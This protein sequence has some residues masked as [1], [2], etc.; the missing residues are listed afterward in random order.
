MAIKLSSGEH[1]SLTQLGGS[2][3]NRIA[4]GLGW[5]HRKGFLGMAQDV[6]L[7]ASAILFDADKN[8]V[9]DVWFG[10]LSSKKGSVQHLGDDRAGGRDEGDPNEVIIVD[11]KSIPA[12]I[13]SVVFVVSSFSGE[14][15]NGVPFAFCNVVDAASRKEIARYDLQSAEGEHTGY[16][17]AKVVKIEG[18]WKFHAVGAHCAG[19]QRTI[20]DIQAIARQHA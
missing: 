10:H 4:V 3:L 12:Q 18:E 6:D 9:D 8:P 17:V 11:L 19:R 5:G 15:F 1:V 20:R 14:T 2:G 7:D 16:I 13:R